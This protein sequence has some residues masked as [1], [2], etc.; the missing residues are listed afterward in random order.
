VIGSQLT[1]S[2]TILRTF[3]CLLSASES[4]CQICIAKAKI[5]KTIQHNLAHKRF[6]DVS[7]AENSRAKNLHFSDRGSTYLFADCRV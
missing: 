1:A 5:Y 4:S 3:H 7:Y 2:N 6:L